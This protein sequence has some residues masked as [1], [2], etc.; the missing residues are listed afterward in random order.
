MLENI[1]FVMFPSNLLPDYLLNNEAGIFSKFFFHF[2]S[3]KLNNETGMVG[4]YVI[5]SHQLLLWNVSEVRRVIKICRL[6]VLYIFP[7]E[8]F[9]FDCGLFFAE[10][11]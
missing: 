4:T 8:M 10:E 11:Q 1:L 2:Q 3:K 7:Y 5:L 6:I 9:R